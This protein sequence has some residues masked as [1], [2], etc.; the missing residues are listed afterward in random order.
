MT[1][2]EK[3]CLKWKEFQRNIGSSYND[4]RQNADFSDVT[5]VCDENYQIEA[6]RIILTASS[7][8]FDTILKKNK[9]SHPMLYMRG[10]N[11]NSMEAIVDFI[12]HGE[13]NICQEDLDGFLSL[14]E[15]L[16]LKGL[17]PSDKESPIDRLDV[18]REAILK[19]AQGKQFLEK[20]SEVVNPTQEMKH[21]VDHTF[22]EYNSTVPTDL[23]KVIMAVD[24]NTGNFNLQIE[25]MMMKICDGEFNW[26]CAVCGKRTKGSTTQMKRH[27]E[28]HLDG[29]SYSCTHCGKVCKSR[30]ILIKH[31]SL[32]HR[33]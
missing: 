16:Q 10:L 27:V 9:H 7:P 28:I 26:K 29:L 6:H 23:G 1:L 18:N 30:T 20:E 32:N 4:L 11:A 15:E 25:T 19:T 33:K 12:Y 24:A 13:A 21:S 2:A 17:A 22:S 5:L 14:A 31:I 8:F 3:F